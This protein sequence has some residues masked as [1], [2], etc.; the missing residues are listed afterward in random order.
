MT[1]NYSF[2]IIISYFPLYY[3]QNNGSLLKVAA[4]VGELKTCQLLID[5]GVDLFLKNKLGLTALDFFKM[6]R[7]RCVYFKETF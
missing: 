3:P 7:I 1:L 4:Q 2:E 6:R 5:K